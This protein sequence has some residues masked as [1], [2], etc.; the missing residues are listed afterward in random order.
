M[1]EKPT[2]ATSR[3]KQVFDDRKKGDQREEP[4]KTN[5]AYGEWEHRSRNNLM[6]PDANAYIEATIK[7]A[8][9]TIRELNDPLR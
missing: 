9:T 3:L 5:P 1:I 4:A 2:E 6:H 8:E 7:R